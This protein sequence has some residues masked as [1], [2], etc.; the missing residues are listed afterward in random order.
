MQI[1]KP[2]VEGKVTQNNRISKICISIVRNIFSII[3]RKDKYPRFQTH[4]GG[5][6]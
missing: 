5:A 2:F 6:S 4:L 1:L 3:V